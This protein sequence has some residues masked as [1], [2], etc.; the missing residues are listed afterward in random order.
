MPQVGARGV[1]LKALF[2][3]IR[4][5]EAMPRLGIEAVGRFIT[6][7]ALLKLYCKYNCTSERESWCKKE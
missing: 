2:F 1:S 6:I 3:L 5:P 4:N 7:K